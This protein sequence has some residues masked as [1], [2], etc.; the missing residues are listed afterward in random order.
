MLQRC[1]SPSHP[2][3]DH[4]HSKGIE[5]CERWRIKGGYD[6]FLADL[7]EPPEGMTLERINNAGPYSPENCRWATWKE[8]SANREQGGKKNK[9]DNSLAGKARAAGLPY[10]VVYSRHVLHLWSLDKALSTPV[11]TRGKSMR[12]KPIPYCVK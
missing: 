5:V 12:R 7:G 8:Q 11:S 6:N 3:F 9:D 1:Y 4:Y 10:N 2:A